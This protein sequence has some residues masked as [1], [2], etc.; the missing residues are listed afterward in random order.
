MGL[1]LSSL[2][3]LVRLWFLLSIAI[4]RRVIRR[5]LLGPTLPSWGW[6]TDLTVAIARTAIVFASTVPEDPLINQFGLR[7]RAPVQSE[8][9]NK[10]KVS[11]IKF[12]S[13]KADRFLRLNES[14]DRA[15]VLY[16][17]GGGYVFGNPGTHRQHIARLV[18]RTETTAYVPTYRLAPKDPF[19][20]ALDDAVAAYRAL[21]GSGVDP[22]EIIVAGD[23]AG[24]GLALALLLT[25]RDGCMDLPKG[26][27]LFSPYTDLEHTGYTIETNAATDYLP[28]TELRTPNRFYTDAAN[29]KNPI[30]SPIH[31]DLTGLPPMLVFAGA[32]EMILA[33]STRLAENASRDG[34]EATLR[35]ADEMIHVWPAI[36]PWEPASD[37]ALDDAATWINALYSEP[38]RIAPRI[39]E[40]DRG[41]SR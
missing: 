15:T 32:A 36:V 9:R 14:S 23:S 27:I 22:S 24:G 26:A 19:P 31:A 16:F 40:G 11:R 17:H 8:L 25:L 6:R 39:E 2:T 28:R 3:N 21:T 12:G 29:L 38:E 13:L 33:D 18:D 20:A 37:Q 1:T 7:V 5:L 35:I 41:G 4:V 30:V 34:V 10:V